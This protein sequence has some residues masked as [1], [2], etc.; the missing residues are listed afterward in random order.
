MNPAHDPLRRAV[1]KA[2]EKAAD[3]NGRLSRH[4]LTLALRDV[5]VTGPCDH[6][7]NAMHT[8][9][10]ICEE[11]Q[12]AL[13]VDGGSVGDAREESK[14]ATPKNAP[15]ELPGR[16]VPPQQEPEIAE[17]LD[18]VLAEMQLWQSSPSAAF[19]QIAEQF[20]RETGFIAPGK[21]VPMEMASTQQDERRQ[22]RYNEWHLQRRELRSAEED[23]AARGGNQAAG[24]VSSPPQPPAGDS[25]TPVPEEK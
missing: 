16:A 1:D 17:Q 5:L 9:E 12:Q 15:H 14:P 8:V 25:S 19:E 21:S 24:S 20:Y 10:Y 18:A 11:C 7:P 6:H 2:F 3:T 22:Q 4:A 13:G 23:Q